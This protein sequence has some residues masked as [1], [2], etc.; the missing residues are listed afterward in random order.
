MSH[1]VEVVEV[2]AH[3]AP[4]V[5]VMAGPAPP[6]AGTETPAGVTVYEHAAA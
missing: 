2:H 4:V 5:T 1:G 3:P 6:A